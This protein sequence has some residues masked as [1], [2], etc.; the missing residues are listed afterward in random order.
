MTH[1]LRILS[2]AKEDFHQAANEPERFALAPENDL[3]EIDIRQSSFKTPSGLTYRVVFNVRDKTCLHS[4]NT[5]PRA[6]TAS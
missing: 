2:R 3:I 1:P 5:R 4:S 6:T